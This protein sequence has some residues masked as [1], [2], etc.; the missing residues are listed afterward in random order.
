MARETLATCKYKP[1]IQARKLKAH[2]EAIG[3]WVTVCPVDIHIIGS[4]IA[5]HPTA[6]LIFAIPNP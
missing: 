2:I 6:T 1:D 5:P 3:I 4:P